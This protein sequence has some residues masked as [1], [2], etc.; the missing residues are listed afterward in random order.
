MKKKFIF[1]KKLIQK[2]IQSSFTSNV[3]TFLVANETRPI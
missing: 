1:A 2:N 3:R